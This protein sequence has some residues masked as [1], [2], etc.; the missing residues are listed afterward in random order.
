MLAGLAHDPNRSLLGARLGGAAIA[1]N[2]AGDGANRQK[3]E[4][5]RQYDLLHVQI[6]SPGSWEQNK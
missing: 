5:N 6:L 4:Q 2:G 1:A 3:A